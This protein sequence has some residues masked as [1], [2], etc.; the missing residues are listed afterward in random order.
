M[1]L[2]VYAGEYDAFIEKKI[3]FTIVFPCHLLQT[4]MDSFLK[5]IPLFYTSSIF[6]KTYPI[7]R[8]KLQFV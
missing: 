8:G 2:S 6:I 5:T 7:N 1:A 4:H 3:E